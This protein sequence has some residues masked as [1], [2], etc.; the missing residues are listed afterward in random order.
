MEVTAV[1]RSYCDYFD[2]CMADTIS[3]KTVKQLRPGI[4]D[5]DKVFETKIRGYDDKDLQR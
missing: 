5:A 3:N 4:P 2:K 1:D